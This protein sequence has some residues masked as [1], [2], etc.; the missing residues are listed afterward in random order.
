MREKHYARIKVL[1]NLWGFYFFYW[2]LAQPFA[3]QS[4]SEVTQFFRQFWNDL[5]NLSEDIVLAYSKHLVVWN[6]IS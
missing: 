1:Q 2:G 3:V 6:L 5:E 4:D